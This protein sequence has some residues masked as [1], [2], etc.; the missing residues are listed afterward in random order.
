M[1][2][3]GGPTVIVTVAGAE[4]SGRGESAAAAETAAVPAPA[5]VVRRREAGSPAPMSES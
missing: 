2:W 5:L 3:G 1:Y 4:M